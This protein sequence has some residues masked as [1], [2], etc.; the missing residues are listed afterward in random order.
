M[1]KVKLRFSFDGRKQYKGLLTGIENDEL[2]IQEG[3]ELRQQLSQNIQVFKSVIQSSSHT[4]IQPIIIGENKEASRCEQA[5][6]DAGYF[7]R[8]VH[9]PTVPKGQSRLRITLSAQHSRD[10]INALAQQISRVMNPAG[11]SL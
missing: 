7:V 8:A 1:V 3:D 5:L 6:I 4:Q 11:G 9:H 10:Q 2:L